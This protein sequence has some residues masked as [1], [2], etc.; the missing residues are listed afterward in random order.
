MCVTITLYAY[1][2]PHCKHVLQCH[3]VCIGCVKMSH[4]MNMFYNV[5]FYAYVTMSVYMRLMLCHIV[6]V[7][8]HGMHMMCVTVSQHMPMMCYNVICM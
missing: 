4:R 6:C 5:T 8:S 7:M 3:I 2:M 1:T